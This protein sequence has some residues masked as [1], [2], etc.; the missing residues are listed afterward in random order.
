MH[1]RLT[2]AERR[3]ERSVGDGAARKDAGEA[4]GSGSEDASRMAREK[5]RDE[6]G[7]AEGER[8]KGVLRKLQ[9]HKV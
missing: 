2:I 7:Y 8:K 9:L 5:E 3:A 1:G 6:Q 4:E